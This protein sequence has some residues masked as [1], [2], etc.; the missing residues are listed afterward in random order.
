MSESRYI[1][2]V[3]EETFD[4][5]VLQNSHTVPVLV[6]FWAE[7]CQ[8]CKM[9]MPVLAKLAAEYDGKFILAKVDTKQQQGLAMRYGIRSIPSVKLFIGGEAVDEFNGALPEAEIRAFLGAHIASAGDG[10]LAEAN[11]LIGRGE[12]EPALALLERARAEE[13]GNQQIQIAYIGLKAALGEIDEAERLLDAL[14][15]EQQQSPEANGLRARFAFDRLLAQ[16]PAEA[17]LNQAQANGSATST[18]EQL[19]QLA[20]Y[21]ISENDLGAAL[22][23]LLQLM[24]KDRDYGNDAGRKGMLAVFS[25]LGDSGELV[26][27]YRRRMFNLLH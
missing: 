16:A 2:D 10:L 13:P 12:I 11:A 19:H 18:S 1:V 6:D 8:P 23:L 22:E 20:A 27:Q 3:T 17:Q 5:Y 4:T 26:T 14:P 7:W 15:A 9:L 21:R 24:S 25:M